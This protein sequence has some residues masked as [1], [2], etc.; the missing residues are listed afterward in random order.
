[1]QSNPKHGK[2][3]EQITPLILTYNETPNI[4]RTLGQL[5]WARDIVVVDSFSSDETL[6]LVSRFAQVRVFQRAFET[7]MNQWAFG[8]RETGI[9]SEW[10]LALDADYVLTPEL[11]D[12]LRTLRPAAGTNGYR[13][14]FRYC[15]GGKPLRSSVYPPVTTLY[16]R[17]H[18][19]YVQDGHTQRIQVDG[20][21]QDLQFPILHDD[22][23][24][25]A[26]WI[27]AQSRYMRLEAE[28]LL[29]SDFHQLG[30]ADRLRR[31]RVLAPLVMFVY[32]LFVRLN[33]LDGRVGLYYAF[34]RMFSEI[35]LSLY[36]IEH[37]LSLRKP[38][39]TRKT[40]QGSSFEINVQPEP[41]TPG[42]QTSGNR[43]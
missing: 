16:R 35:L 11:V 22:R 32:C 41:E 25:L 20:E 31:A 7:H 38:H 17:K 34:Q 19:A 1:M 12:E 39:P 42:R 27:Q 40:R 14:R 4:E 5:S 18:S 26:H 30:W 10:V 36:L 33:I 43:E 3:L 29:Q 24:P 23:K 13:A 28:K 8:L 2:M 6:E 37:D 21:I 15:I 9:K